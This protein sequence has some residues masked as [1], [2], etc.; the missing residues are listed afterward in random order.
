MHVHVYDQNCFYIYM[1]FYNDEVPIQNVTMYAIN[2]HNCVCTCTCTSTCTVHVHVLFDVSCNKKNS[3][4]SI[5]Q[6]DHK[7]LSI[8]LL[9]IHINPKKICQVHI[10][11]S[12][13]AD[14]QSGQ[15][16]NLCK[17]FLKQFYEDGCGSSLHEGYFSHTYHYS[18][19][20][21]NLQYSGMFLQR[22]S[23]GHIRPWERLAFIQS[24]H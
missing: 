1:Y 15:H 7:F 19:L 13:F 12:Y 18:Q 10:I 14:R 8:S 20:L 5:Q 2:K 4:F 21:Y 16:T 17:Q 6:S 3:S 9:L 22:P 23:S 11:V 24:L